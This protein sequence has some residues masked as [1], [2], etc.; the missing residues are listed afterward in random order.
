[1]THQGAT[2]HGRRTVILAAATALVGTLAACRGDEPTHEETAVTISSLDPQDARDA[3]ESLMHDAQAA[4]DETFEGLTWEDSTQER[5]EDREG[6]CRLAPPS[7]R[8]DTYL[9]KDP[10]YHERIAAALTTALEAHDLPAAPTPT[11]GTGGWLTTSSTAEGIT[12]S[13]RA[14]GFAELSV[15]VDLAQTCEDVG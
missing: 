5:L 10:A 15:H 13:F 1:M 7:R 11:G 3:A 8:C 12:L 4:L 14:K 9:G 6:G 2:V